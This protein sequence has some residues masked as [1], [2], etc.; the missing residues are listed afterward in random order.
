MGSKPETIAIAGQILRGIDK[1]LAIDLIFDEKPKAQYVIPQ[2][3]KGVLDMIPKGR[4]PFIGIA[5][6][7]QDSISFP[8]YDFKPESVYRLIDNLQLVR[9]KVTAIKENGGNLPADAFL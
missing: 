1:A 8:R 2:M 9:D 7:L 3:V 5:G 4:P 6:Q